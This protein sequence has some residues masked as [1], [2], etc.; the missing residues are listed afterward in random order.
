MNK[1]S[2]AKQTVWTDSSNL[3]ERNDCSVKAIALATGKPYAEVHEAFRL[4]G[5]KNRSGTYKHQQEA[6][7]TR[8]GFKREKFLDLKKDNGSKYT[9]KTVSQFCHTGNWMVYI[10][11]HV[12]AVIDGN[13]LDWTEG[14]RHRITQA[15]RITPI[16]EEPTITP[17]PQIKQETKKKKA[18]VMVNGITF[19]KLTNALRANGF[20]VTSDWRAV[21]KQLKATGWAN[22]KGYTFTQV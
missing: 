13:V 22:Y 5:R 18:K 16:D 8:L 3:N 15:W 9:P 17:V 20:N 2:T 11:H 19:N 12:F 1:Y 7:L 21:Q 6:V 4:E 10:P 14:R